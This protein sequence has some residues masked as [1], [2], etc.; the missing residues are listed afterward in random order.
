[1]LFL[2]VLGRAPNLLEPL[3]PH[4]SNGQTKCQCIYFKA[5][6]VQAWDGAVTCVPT[7]LS[8]VLSLFSSDNELGSGPAFREL[9]V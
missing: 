5:P 6:T 2:C 7:V 9:L 4:L 1:M 8:P 3:H